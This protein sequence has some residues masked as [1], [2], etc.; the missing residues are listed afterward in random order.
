MYFENSITN[1]KIFNF[2]FKKKITGTPYIFTN[3]NALG[4]INLR[5]ISLYLSEI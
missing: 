2:N 4:K 5:K 3:I 1:G